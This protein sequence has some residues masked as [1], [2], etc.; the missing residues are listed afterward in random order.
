MDV[1]NVRTTTVD[2]YPLLTMTVDGK[3]ARLGT[4]QKRTLLNKYNVVFLG[5]AFEEELQVTIPADEADG[6]PET[7][8]HGFTDDPQVVD[9][10]RKWLAKYD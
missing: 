6:Q 5:P 1:S 9:L 10:Y 8:L 3:E 4:D 2:R 7:T